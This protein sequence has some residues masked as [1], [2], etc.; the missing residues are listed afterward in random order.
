MEADQDIVNV[1]VHKRGDIMRK[2]KINYDNKSIQ[3]FRR[4]VERNFFKKRTLHYFEQLE[5]RK[6][7]VNLILNLHAM[8][9]ALNKMFPITIYSNIG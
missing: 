3:K 5:D 4:V 6:A 8:R 7:N 2:V 1:R 9:N